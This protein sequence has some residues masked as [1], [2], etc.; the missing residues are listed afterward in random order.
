MGRATAIRSVRR[1]T[2]SL[3]HLAPEIIQWPN[4]DQIEHIISEFKTTS[5]FPDV[6]GAI[7][8]THIKISKPKADGSGYINR[9]GFHSIILQVLLLFVTKLMK[10]L[11]LW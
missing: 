2:N 11:V 3:V 8:G 1:V 7:D 9:K 5:G 10:T 6:L 4:K